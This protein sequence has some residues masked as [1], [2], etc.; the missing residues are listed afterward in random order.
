MAMGGIARRRGIGGTGSASAAPTAPSNG[1]GGAGTL[2]VGP[3]AFNTQPAQSEISDVAAGRV[4]LG[5]INLT[6][7]GFLAFYVWTRSAQGGG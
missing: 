1:A 2:N 4:T 3:I 5:L 7:I 6:L